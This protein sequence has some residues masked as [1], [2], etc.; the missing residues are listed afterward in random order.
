MPQDIV[1][2]FFKSF[3]YFGVQFNFHYKSREKYHSAT[4]GLI[5]LCFIVLTLTYISLNIIAF[6]QRKNCS[7]I[8]YTTR[9]SETDEISFFNYS[10]NYAFGISCGGSTS[11]NKI[12][13][14]LS[15]T[16]NHITRITKDGEGTKEKNR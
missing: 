7:I 15:V 6:I 8:Y 2:R 14:M 16:I 5:F 11:Q 4:G 13:E 9:L 3:D 10:T 12:E 1:K